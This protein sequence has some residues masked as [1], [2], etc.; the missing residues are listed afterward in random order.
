M[1]SGSLLKKAINKYGKETFHKEELFFAFSY[2]DLIWAEKYF[3]DYNFVNR[4][5]TYNQALGGIG[6]VLFHSIETRQ[7]MSD[8]HKGKPKSKEA[9]IKSGLSRRG[10]KRTPDQVK[11]ISDAHKGYRWSDN[12]KKSYSKS[13]TGRSFSESHCQS[14]SASAI[15]RPRCSCLFCHKELQINNLQYHLS[16]NFNCL[17][18]QCN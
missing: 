16:H 5:D 10:S 9:S 14:I 7:K 11:K 6:G 1:G 12:R 13:Q 2:N 4:R 15:N 17:K 8:A 18:I 3:V